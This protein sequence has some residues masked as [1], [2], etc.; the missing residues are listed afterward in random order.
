MGKDSE[1]G[2]R[3]IGIT[4]DDVYAVDFSTDIDE[5]SKWK[6]KD[7]I[8]HK[9]HIP[10]TDSWDEVCKAVAEME[11][12]RIYNEML[13]KEQ[14]EAAV[15]ICN[16][17]NKHRLKALFPNLCVLGTDHCDDK[18]YMVTDKTIAENIRESLKWENKQ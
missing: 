10:F 5:P 2:C 15:I 6:D 12:K 11:D 13:M 9:G 3:M 1:R 16:R 18:I 4:P 7:G 17:E 8:W 14:I